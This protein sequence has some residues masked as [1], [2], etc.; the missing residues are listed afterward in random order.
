LCT[1][2]LDHIIDIPVSPQARKKNPE[3]PE[4]WRA[5]F[6]AYQEPKGERKGVVT[7]LVDPVNICWTSYLASIGSGGK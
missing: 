4:T 3:L 5:R 2:L 1:V 7:S 6:I